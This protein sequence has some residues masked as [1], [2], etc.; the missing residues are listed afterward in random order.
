M[1]SLLSSCFIFGRETKIH[2][3]RNVISFHFIQ[4][5]KNSFSLIAKLIARLF[6]IL[7]AH[8]INRKWKLFQHKLLCRRCRKWRYRYGSGL[9]HMMLHLARRQ[10]RWIVTW[11]LGVNRDVSD[12]AADIVGDEM[13][14][15]ICRSVLTDK[16]TRVM[17]T[18]VTLNW[19]ICLRRPNVYVSFV[20]ASWG[21]R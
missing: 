13:I 16:W 11:T 18:Q 19:T 8:S 10:F 2:F 21:H 1:F 20:C 14:N 15:V 6:I 12:E 9:N 17:H 7:D 3:A 5:E 4:P